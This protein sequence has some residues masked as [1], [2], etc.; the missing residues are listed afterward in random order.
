MEILKIGATRNIVL[1]IDDAT[2]VHAECHIVQ[3]IILDQQCL[4]YIELLFFRYL[5]ECHDLYL[6]LDPIR[7]VGDDRDWHILALDIVLCLER[8]C[9]LI[10]GEGE[11]HE[12]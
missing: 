9:V 3:H 11:L 4:E 8:E 2:L 7:L 5:V 10:V 12:F 1:G 6:D